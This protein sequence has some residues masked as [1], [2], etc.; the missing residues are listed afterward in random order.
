MAQAQDHEQIGR[1][2]GR[3]LL[4]RGNECQVAQAFLMGEAGRRDQADR[5]RPVP[6]GHRGHVACERG[7]HLVERILGASPCRQGKEE[8][9]QG[10]GAS[11]DP[12]AGG[13]R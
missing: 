13:G 7:A 8:R 1:R 4:A 9:Q 3:Q 11:S 12:R 2:Q 6:C 10:A 5:G